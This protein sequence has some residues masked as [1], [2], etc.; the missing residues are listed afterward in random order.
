[1]IHYIDVRTWLM[2]SNTTLK[3]KYN[4]TYMCKHVYTIYI[5][6]HNLHICTC[7]HNIIAY[8]ISK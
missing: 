3:Y 2:L 8:V 5:C 1:M 4:H 6:V 7:I